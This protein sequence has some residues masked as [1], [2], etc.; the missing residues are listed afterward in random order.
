MKEEPP[1]LPPEPG[2]GK[3]SWGSG[4]RRFNPG[5]PF[6]LMLCA[7]WVYRALAP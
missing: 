3:I 1:E 4:G 5:L 6:T 7:I 2:A